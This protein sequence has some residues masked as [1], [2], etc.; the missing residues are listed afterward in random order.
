MWAWTLNWN[1]IRADLV[2]GSCPLE[3]ADIDRIHDQAGATALLSLQSDVCLGHF[4][5]DYA[6]HRLHGENLGLEMRRAPMRD[7]D[8]PDQRRHLARAIR[9]L[10]ELLS[11]RHRVYLHCTAG[12]GRSAL[13]ALG[14]LSCVEAYRI[15]EALELLKT[16]RPGI[17]PSLEAYQG[18]RAD[19]VDHYR[20]EIERRAGQAYR[21]R[22]STH[23]EGSAA[24]DWYAAERDVVRELLTAPPTRCGESV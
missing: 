12:L 16:R 13:T 23:A 2:I 15:E 19:L 10:H 22:L 21:E 14:Y 11:Q 18:C 3:V 24:S 20:P 6:V 8:I 17:V 9:T 5:I 7:F 4:G 1:E